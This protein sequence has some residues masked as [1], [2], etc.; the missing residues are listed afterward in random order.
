MTGNSIRFLRY[1]MGLSRTEF[2]SILGC[3]RWT[4]RYWEL[5]HRSPNE[6]SEAKLK[7]LERKVKSLKGG[8][9]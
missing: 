3:S 8:T 7:K 4:V 6:E 2:A 1:S 5:G 9:R